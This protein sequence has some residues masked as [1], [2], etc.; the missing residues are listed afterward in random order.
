MNKTE[1]ITQIRQK[2]KELNELLLLAD[3][4]KLDIHWHDSYWQSTFP[5]TVKKNKD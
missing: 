4:S 2:E 1:I 5:K 3:D